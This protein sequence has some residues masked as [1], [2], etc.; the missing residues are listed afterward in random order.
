MGFDTCT[1]D[2]NF[3]ETTNSLH[4]AL[5]LLF[6]RNG[7]KKYGINSAVVELCFPY[8]KIEGE[9]QLKVK[10]VAFQKRTK[11]S[12]ECNRERSDKDSG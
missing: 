3:K 7:A 1:S 4:N 10:S 9:L 2:A 5:R 6:T 8:F 12:F 11:H